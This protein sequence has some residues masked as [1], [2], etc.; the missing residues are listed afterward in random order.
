MKHNAHTIRDEHEW[1]VQQIY[2]E[3]MKKMAKAK[4]VASLQSTAPIFRDFWNEQI[5]IADAIEEFML[6][7]MDKETATAMAG[8]G[9]RPTQEEVEQSL[10]VL[11]NDETKQ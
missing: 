3:A 9:K 11:L 2:T 7:G 1:E 10:S 8:D 5:T 6:L 4:L